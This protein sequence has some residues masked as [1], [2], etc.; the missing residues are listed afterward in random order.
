MPHP[1]AKQRASRLRET[2]SQARKRIAN[3]LE[4]SPNLGNARRLPPRSS[5]VSMSGVLQ[6]S[7]ARRQV[8]VARARCRGLPRSLAPCLREVGA[9]RPV[10]PK[11]ETLRRPRSH[12]RAYRVPSTLRG[13]R[14]AVGV[15]EVG[16]SPRRVASRR[17]MKSLRRGAIPMPGDRREDFRSRDSRTADTSLLAP[18]VVSRAVVSRAPDGQCRKPRESAK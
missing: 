3:A 6:P 5:L 11:R 7:P 12:G 2:I 16:K 4:R 13:F 1:A 15:S 8:S 18:S 14:R 9:R 10:P 17:C